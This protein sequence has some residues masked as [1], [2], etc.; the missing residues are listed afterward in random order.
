MNNT[1]KRK[2]HTRN[3]YQLLGQDLVTPSRFVLCYAQP[4]SKDAVTVKG[5]TGTAVKLGLDNGVEIV[6]L[7]YKENVDRI[8]TWLKI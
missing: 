6:N 1:K 4:T 7:Y 2:L 8:K 5:G 3:I